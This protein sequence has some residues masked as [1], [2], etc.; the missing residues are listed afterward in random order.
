MYI[1]ISL[2]DL[3][4]DFSFNPFATGNFFTANFRTV[5]P[6]MCTVLEKDHQRPRLRHFFL[7][8]IIKEFRKKQMI[9]IKY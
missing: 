4:L 1:S 2:K 3:Y 7:I 9:K 5:A 6:R 8:F